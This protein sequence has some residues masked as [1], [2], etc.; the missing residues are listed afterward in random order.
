VFQRGFSDRNYMEFYHP[1]NIAQEQ[2]G[3]WNSPEAILKAA[4]DLTDPPFVG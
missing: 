2:F 4:T 1:D 3:D